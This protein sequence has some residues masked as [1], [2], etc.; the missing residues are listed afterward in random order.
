MAVEVEDGGFFLGLHAVGHAI[1]ERTER[2]VQRDDTG[3]GEAHAAR[4]LAKLAPT[5]AREQTLRRSPARA[6]GAS[7]PPQ[8]GGT[9]EKT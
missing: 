2:G 4:K 1:V 5:R 7:A 6:P 9:K 8:L 3:A